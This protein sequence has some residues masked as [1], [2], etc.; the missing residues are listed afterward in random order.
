M[1]CASNSLF[2][3]LPNLEL[4]SAFFCS[5]PPLP[6]STFYCQALPSSLGCLC[7]FPPLSRFCPCKAGSSPGEAGSGSSFSFSSLGHH[8]WTFRRDA[9]FWRGALARGRRGPLCSWAPCACPHLHPPWKVHLMGAQ[10][11]GRD[12]VLAP[13]TQPGILNWLYYSFNL[14]QEVSSFSISIE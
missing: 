9:F 4:R 1:P 3:T 10:A 14:C 7:F 5:L 12:G 6:P 2:L 11:L 8:H 13:P